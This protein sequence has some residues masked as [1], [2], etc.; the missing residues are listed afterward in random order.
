MRRRDVLSL[1]G[2]AAMSWPRAAWTQQGGP[3]KRVGFLT[4]AS[5]KDEEG[6][7]AAFLDGLHGHGLIEGKNLKL[8][9]RYSEGDVKRLTPLAQEL[10]AL[11]PDV[12]VGAEPS[13]AKVLK[14][15]APTLPIVCPQLTDA[16]LSDLV[17]SYARP[18]AN[19]TGLAQTVEGLTGKLIELVQEFVPG[20]VRVG[21]LSNPTGA[22]MRFFAHSVEEAARGRGIL[23]VTEE[24]ATPNELPS[25]LDRLA[26]QEPQAII[27][28]VNGLFRNEV[29]QIV[30]LM[31]AARLP[32]IFAQ[33]QGAKAGGLAS[34]GIDLKDN[35][36]RAADYVDKILKGAKPADMPIEFPTKI[37]LVINLKTARTLRI[38][39]PLFLQQRADEIIE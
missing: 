27:V 15:V 38:D 2:G 10:I 29:A 22:S 36:R 35:Y 32:T 26:R 6:V 3:V 11:R 28:P 12:L 4:L 31:T 18:G 7:L 37:E 1:L 24:A 30:Q 19:V 14:S 23:L 20:A 25:A 8:D 13:P 34:Y 39:V 17:A 9:Y 16:Q 33:P 21:F 5:S